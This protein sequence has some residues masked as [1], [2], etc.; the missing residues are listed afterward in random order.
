MIIGQSLGNHWTIIR[1]SLDNHLSFQEL[2]STKNVVEEFD[3]D[4]KYQ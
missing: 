4:A 1:Q 3:K 2:R